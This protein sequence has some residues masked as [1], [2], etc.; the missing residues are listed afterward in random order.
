M[1]EGHSND[2]NSICTHSFIYKAFSKINQQ[3]GTKNKILKNID[4]RYIASIRQ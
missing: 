4:T 1:I 2:T 3:S